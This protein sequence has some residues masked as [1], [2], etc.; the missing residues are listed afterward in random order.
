MIYEKQVPSW[1]IEV[2]ATPEEMDNFDDCRLDIFTGILE[3]ENGLIKIYPFYDL[4]F[5]EELERQVLK[6]IERGHTF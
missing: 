2:A 5:A 4:E 6:E 3:L 1:I